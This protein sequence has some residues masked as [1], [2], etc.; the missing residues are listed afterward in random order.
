MMDASPDILNFL[1]RMHPIVVHFPIGFLLLASLLEIAVKWPKFVALRDYTRYLWGLSSLT[2][3]LAIVFGYFLS[4]SGDYNESTLFWHK[5]SAVALFVFSTIIYVVQKK[6]IKL[7]FN[8][9]NVLVAMVAIN[10]IYTGHLGGNLT[11]GSTY[12]FEYAPNII[13]KIAGMPPKAIPRKQVVVI[14]SAD[15]YLDLIAP[16]MNNRC[17]SCHNSDKKKGALD[18]TT[19]SNMMAGGENGG[20]VVPK[21]P[22]SSEIY[23]RIT[24]P[25]SH[26]D[27]MPTEGKPPLSEDE[28]AFIGW[29]IKNSAPSK[30]Y[31]TALN[32][33]DTLKIKIENYLGLD[34]NKLLS[35]ALKPPKKRV[36]DSL[37]KYGF[38]LNQL[39]KDNY[40]LEANFSLS[41]KKLT[42]NSLEYLI[43]LKEHLIWLNLSN[44]NMQ[45]QDLEK[46]GQLENLMKLNLSKT[47]ITDEGL[48]N[49][50]S[51]VNL[52]ALNLYG[53]K[54]S[55]G[56]LTLLPELINLQRIYISQSE[57]DKE[58]V[59]S[60]QKKNKNLTIVF[61]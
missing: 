38:I 14:D 15:V 18:L 12:L 21:D 35:K 37:V 45:D 33:D 58:I 8:G 49:L 46:I 50:G 53:T 24:L 39:M 44:S 31:V 25:E 23:R 19:Y 52:E 30:G 48:K 1:G 9:E 47:A 5:W 4:L 22:G 3:F 57:V 32:L 27:F 26:E 40:F 61:D 11:H 34:K 20:S 10:V 42:P 43:K 55:E 59:D 7:P 41:E 2:A 13:R 29:W 60:I 28:V 16:I 17:A 56:L 6:R 51:L 54:V 36:V